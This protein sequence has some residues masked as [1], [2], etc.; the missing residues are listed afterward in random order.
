MIDNISDINDL[1]RLYQLYIMID[2]ILAMQSKSKAGINYETL[3]KFKLI[4]IRINYLH[5]QESLEK[6]AE[7]EYETKDFYEEE[8]KLTVLVKVMGDA[9]NARNILINKYR[10]YS[11]LPLI[12]EDNIGLDD[13]EYYRNKLDCVSE[14]IK[15]EAYLVKLDSSLSL[16][17]LNIGVKTKEEEDMLSLIPLYEKDLKSYIFDKDS[18]IKTLQKYGFDVKELFNND[19]RFNNKYEKISAIYSDACDK[20]DA[21]KFVDKNDYSD[22]IRDITLEYNAARTNKNIVEILKLLLEDKKE[23]DEFLEKRV[24]IKT[25]LMDLNEVIFG[26][27]F[28]DL[29]DLQL[30]ACEKMDSVHADIVRMKED[31]HKNNSLITRIKKN[32]KELKNKILIKKQKNEEKVRENQVIS[33]ENS[34]ISYSRERVNKVLRYVYDKLNNSS[35]GNESIDKKADDEIFVDVNNSFNKDD[36]KS[37]DIFVSRDNP[38]DKLND[39]IESYDE[40]FEDNSNGLFIEEEN[41]NK[42]NDFK[43]VD[44]GNNIFNGQIN[45]E[46]I[47]SN[48]QFMNTNNTFWPNIG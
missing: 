39:R 32:Q 28:S 31:I 22:V 38:F 24:S 4:S 23:Y 27:E 8:K 35:L 10:A 26:K 43:F 25:Y 45:P 15:N 47:N 42:V 13:L 12:L 29:L 6:I 7:L 20:Y 16:L 9:Y 3:K 19:S 18:V 40:I 34:Y 2:K 17:G 37:D 11:A 21:I 41:K 48:V 33:V 1:K 44:L 36:I 14:Y 30:E 46:I 5:M